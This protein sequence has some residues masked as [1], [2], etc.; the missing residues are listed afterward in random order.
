MKKNN[1][2]RAGLILLAMAP[3]YYSQAEETATPPPSESAQA[4]TAAPAPTDAAKPTATK[5]DDVQDMSD[6]LAVFTQIG[7]GYTDKGINLKVSQSYDTG[8]ETTAGM[9]LVELKGILGEAVGWRSKD[10]SIQADD[11]IDSFRFRNFKVNVTNGRAAQLDMT[12]QVEG[13][14]LVADQTAD[15]SYSLIQ[16]LPK[17]GPLNLYPLAGVGVSIGENAIEDDPDHYV[18]ENGNPQTRVRRDS[19]YSIM[20]TYGL[21][22]MYSKLAITDKFWLNY[23]PFWLSTI[24]GSDQYK[25]NYYGL[26]QSHILT[27]EFAASYQF[28]PR[29]NVRYFANWTEETDFA[30]G[31]HRIEFNYQI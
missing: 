18:D 2:Y 1:L 20:G 28:T 10:G 14:P 15:I 5:D 24:S 29:F 27:H 30:D 22:G 8:D 26:D 4:D 13:N 31:D 16:A 7:A 17:M 12:Y 23:N 21:V 19:G 11:S 3:A 25:D 6:P 9:N